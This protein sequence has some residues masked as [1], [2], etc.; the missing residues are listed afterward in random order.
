MRLWRWPRRW[1]GALPE[2]RPFASAGQR[3]FVWL[4][5]RTP[6]KALWPE[7]EPNA[8][9][10]VSQS[11]AEFAFFVAKN[12]EDKL[13][14]TKCLCKSFLCAFVSLRA[15]VAMFFLDSRLPGI[16]I[17]GTRPRLCR[18]QCYTNSEQ[19]IVQRSQEHTRSLSAFGKSGVDRDARL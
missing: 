2:M 13:E 4:R 14:D 8:L 19:G 10:C 9:S 16:G 11:V 18:D 7:P 1:V 12:S 5:P 17:L 3:F 15:F 6:G